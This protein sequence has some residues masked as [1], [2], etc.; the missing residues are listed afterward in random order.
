MRKF[1]LALL[2]LLIIAAVLLTPSYIRYRR[3]AGAVPG[4]VRLAGV[5]VGGQTVG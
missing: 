5:E 1:L 4:W 3:T 2:T